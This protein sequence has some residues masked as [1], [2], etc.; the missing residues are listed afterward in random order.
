MILDMSCM[1]TDAV[2]FEMDETLPP[3]LSLYLTN[4]SNENSYFIACF[5]LKTSERQK[6]DRVEQANGSA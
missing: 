3:Q 6:S 5:P 4:T 2:L 1:L